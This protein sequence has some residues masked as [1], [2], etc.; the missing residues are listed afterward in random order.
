MRAGVD[1][2]FVKQ[3]NLIFE[4]KEVQNLGSCQDLV[5]LLMPHHQQ[6]QEMH[7]LG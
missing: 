3:G 1:E 7:L 6:V 2:S 4:E 5:G